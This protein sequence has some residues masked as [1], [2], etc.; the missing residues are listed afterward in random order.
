MG[1]TAITAE[2]D[3]LTL[4]IVPADVGHS[5]GDVTLFWRSEEHQAGEI[6][7]ILH[8]DHQGQG[9]AREASKALLALGFEQL[10]LH[11]ISGR[12]DARNIASAAACA[13]SACARRPT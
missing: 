4:A 3:V 2:G 10:G 7:F 1:R 6:G 9:Y 11:R 5:V 12:L 8:P 13:G